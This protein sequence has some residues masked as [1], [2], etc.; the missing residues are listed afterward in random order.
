[1]ILDCVA[2]P[3]GAGWQRESWRGMDPDLL[4]SFKRG[5]PD[6]LTRVYR[7]HFDDVARATRRGLMNLGCFSPANLSDVIQEVFVRAFSEMARASYDGLR[8]YRAYLLTITRNVLF[9]WAR[10]N[11]RERPDPDAASAL[12]TVF[13]GLA[14]GDDDQDESPFPPDL[15]SLAATY[16]QRLPAE[17]GAVHQQRYVL[18]KPQREAAEALGISRQSLR[19]LEKRL[20]TGLRR[21]IRRAALAAPPQPPGPAVG[22]TPPADAGP[23]IEAMS[24]ARR[25]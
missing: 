16:V 10:R 25:R 2:A 12:E 14:A 18:A 1:M 11:L 20:V 22:K 7:L 17:L 8:E 3:V 15:V 5:D 6:A 23:E 13:T 21:E 19:T 9:D 24:D 4:R